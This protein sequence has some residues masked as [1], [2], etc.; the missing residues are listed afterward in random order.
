M[1]RKWIKKAM[2]LLT[3][4]CSHIRCLTRETDDKGSKPQMNNH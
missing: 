3:A 2:A 4:G 1:K